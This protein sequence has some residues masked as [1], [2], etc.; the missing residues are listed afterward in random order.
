M[1]NSVTLTR[2]FLTT[3]FK[4][5][6]ILLS[7]RHTRA[8]ASGNTLG[9]RNAV[10]VRRSQRFFG[11]IRFSLNR[12]THGI[13]RF[14]LVVGDWEC[15]SSLKRL[16]RTVQ[17]YEKHIFRRFASENPKTCV[18]KCV[19]THSNDQRTDTAF[20]RIVQSRSMS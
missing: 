20:L 19:E 6:T 16:V 14:R 9:E 12:V 17:N 11:I 2:T 8:Q 4:T 5:N 15:R 3:H 18:S 13:F 7:L 1:T 10:S